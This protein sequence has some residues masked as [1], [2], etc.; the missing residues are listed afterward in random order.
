MS[1]IDYRA[2]GVDIDEG[3][4]AVDL[5]KREV[6]K[7]FNRNVLSELGHFGGLFRA[8]FPGISKPV[9][10]ASTDGVGTKLRVA[11]MSGDYSTVGMDL[12]NHCVNENISSIRSNA[13]SRRPG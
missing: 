7:T 1:G 9:L 8:D 12:V 13:R 3:T 5:M 6:R 2:S 11:S 4:R 10:V